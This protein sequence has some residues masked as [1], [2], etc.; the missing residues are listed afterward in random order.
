MSVAVWGSRCDFLSSSLSSTQN[1][2]KVEHKTRQKHVT[3][4][5]K[6]AQWHCTV[7]RANKMKQ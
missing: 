7:R 4:K 1:G 2:T 3:E 6:R 5:E